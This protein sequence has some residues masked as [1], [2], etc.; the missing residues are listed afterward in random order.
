MSQARRQTSWAGKI[1]IQRQVLC[2]GSCSSCRELWNLRSDSPQCQ[3]SSEKCAEGDTTRWPVEKQV[4][5][6][7][8]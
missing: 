2:S 1:G 6:G 3:S 8:L 4:T 5:G 7:A